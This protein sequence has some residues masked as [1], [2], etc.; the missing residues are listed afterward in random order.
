MNGMRILTTSSNED[1]DMQMQLLFVN[2]KTV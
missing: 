2:Y 1:C